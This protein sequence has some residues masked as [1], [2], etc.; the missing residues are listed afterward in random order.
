MIRLKLTNKKMKKVKGITTIETILVI[1][2]IVIGCVGA[3]TLLVQKYPDFIDNVN[4]KI[5]NLFKSPPPTPKPDPPSIPKPTPDFPYIS[6]DPHN[7]IDGGDNGANRKGNGGTDNSKNGGDIKPPNFD[8]FNDIRINVENNNVLLDSKN[9]LYNF[10]A[11]Y[12]PKTWDFVTEGNG[13]IEYN[14]FSAKHDFN[15]IDYANIFTMDQHSYVKS[16]GN[17]SGNFKLEKDGWNFNGEI[18]LN[19]EL[20]S[21]EAGTETHYSLLKFLSITDG[22]FV[23]GPGVKAG[24]GGAMAIG[25]DKLGYYSYAGAEAYLVKA[26]K[27]LNINADLYF[28]EFETAN[29]VEGGVGIGGS[30]PKIGAIIDRKESITIC[31]GG[32]LYAKLGIG[33]DGCFKIKPKWDAIGKIIPLNN[34]SFIIVNGNNFYVYLSYDDFPLDFDINLIQLESV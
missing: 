15:I 31:Y 20:N 32:S 21:I 5:S 11:I 22:T 30:I 16:G 28:L 24:A 9:N 3:G 14:L 8:N 1:A 6:P 33:I 26:G 19:T 29:T 34:N 18:N 23:K 13:S 25:P 4:N 10:S 17:L 7:E 2:V 12:I 27:K